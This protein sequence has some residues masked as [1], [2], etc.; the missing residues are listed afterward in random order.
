[1]GD[2]ETPGVA[3]IV[4]ATVAAVAEVMSQV[5]ANDAP[6]NDSTAEEPM[7]VLASHGF[8][9]GVLITA[10]IAGLVVLFVAGYVYARRKTAGGRSSAIKQRDLIAMIGPAGAGKTV[11]LHQVRLLK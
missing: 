9:S 5:V 3:H 7:P 10:A 6:V 11:L 8:S 1:M 4:Q 2:K